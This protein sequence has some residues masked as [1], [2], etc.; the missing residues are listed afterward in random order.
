MT[1]TFHNF[2][3]QFIFAQSLGS[4]ETC[5]NFQTRTSFASWTRCL[6]LLFAFTPA[7]ASLA[8]RGHFGELKVYMR[9]TLRQDRAEGPS[10]LATPVLTLYMALSLRIILLIAALIC[11]IYRSTNFI[12]YVANCWLFAPIIAKYLLPM[13]ILFS[14]R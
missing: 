3:S 2:H 6:A 8:L 12:Y 1:G 9:I 14:P 13:V 4:T 7:P 11:T 10:V 5:L